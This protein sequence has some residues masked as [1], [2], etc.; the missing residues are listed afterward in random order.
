V[1]V[2]A[3]RRESPTAASPHLEQLRALLQQAH[4]SV[5][6]VVCQVMQTRLCHSRRRHMCME[7]GGKQRRCLV[8][9]RAQSKRN[10]GHSSSDI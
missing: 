5:V 6:V 1:Q 4:T 3:G 2:M 8:R 7:Q 10:D 9:E